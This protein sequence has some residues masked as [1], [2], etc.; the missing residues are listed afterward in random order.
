M[1]LAI[2][3]GRSSIKYKLFR[4]ELPVKAGMVERIGHGEMLSHVQGWERLHQG[5]A[6]DI[7]EIKTV[8]L[9]F[10][11][12]FRK[13]R[14]VLKLDEKKLAE[15]RDQSKNVPFLEAPAYDIAEI[16]MNV[17]PQAAFWVVF[18]DDFFRDLA[19][20]IADYPVNPELRGKVG[21]YKAGIHGVSHSNAVKKA[22]ADLGMIRTQR[23]VSVHLGDNSSVVAIKEGKCVDTSGG[24]SPFCGIMGMTN[25]GDIDAI[26][27]TQ[28]LDTE[29]FAEKSQRME[30]TEG[31]FGMAGL[32]RVS[33]DM[34][35]ILYLAGYKVE[36]E[37]YIP[38]PELPKEEVYINDA[39]LA[40]E[41]YVNRV[42]KYIGGFVAELGGLDTII[43]TGG[44][45][46]NS[47]EIRTMIM[48]NFGFLKDFEILVI[49][50]NEELE[51][52]LQVENFLSLQKSPDTQNFGL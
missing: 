24:Y 18:D 26:F 33:D 38:S 43:F 6:T 27:L 49:E 29:E 31:K 50:P 45:G 46:Y 9:K 51:M 39:R 15:I 7:N 44:I 2:N 19:P 12:S 52:K 48:S 11:R 16:V 23:T 14:N 42:V 1:V 25:T 13:Y 47:A 30:L 21:I 32:S 40:I 35:D 10:P 5:L 8:V 37:K 20:A 22:Q 17:L 28:L 4:G 41:M 3:V 36:D 34:R